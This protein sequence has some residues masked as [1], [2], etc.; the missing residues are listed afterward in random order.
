MK[1]TKKIFMLLLVILFFINFNPILSGDF[2]SDTNIEKIKDTIEYPNDKTDSFTFVGI[3][4]GK[5][6]NE[7]ETEVNGGLSGSIS[8]L[9]T[10][11]GIS[12][13]NIQF[14]IDDKI[15]KEMSSTLLFRIRRGYPF[16]IF[17]PTWFLVWGIYW[18]ELTDPNTD[19]SEFVF[20]KFKS[21][22]VD[23][24]FDFN[25]N[26]KVQSLKNLYFKFRFPE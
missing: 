5:L 13:F 4:D 17:N 12:N 16:K 3:W 20:G 25:S 14:K 9:G 1:K 18:G 19:N 6:N 23:C 22:L 21:C 7:N 15:Y 11:I 2:V 8:H 24:H 10:R 26:A